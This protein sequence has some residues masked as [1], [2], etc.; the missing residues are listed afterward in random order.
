MSATMA[1][2]GGQVQLEQSNMCLAFNMAPMAKEGFLWAAINETKYLINKPRTVVREEKKR[3]V[4]FPV[5]NKLK[6]AIERHQAIL[7]QNHSSGFLP[8][9]NVTV[10]NLQTRWRC[11]GTG[12]PPHARRRQ[13]MP[14]LP[15]TPP[16]PTSNK[17][18]AELS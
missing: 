12:A 16:A 1:R 14:P 5:H 3:G 11:K 17:S 7:C 15:G 6:A 4:E 2:Q 18:G 13:P 8:C 10:K 9:Q